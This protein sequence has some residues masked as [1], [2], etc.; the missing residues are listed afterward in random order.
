MIVAAEVGPA[1]RYA[2]PSSATVC[3]CVSLDPRVF[4][5]ET[6]SASH[7][8]NGSPVLNALHVLAATN[9]LSDVPFLHHC[10]QSLPAMRSPPTQSLFSKKN[11]LDARGHLGLSKSPFP[12]S[13]CLHRMRILL[14][15]DEASLSKRAFTVPSM[16][17]PCLPLRC[18]N[19]FSHCVS[20]LSM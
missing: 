14:A 12:V 4:S 20:S 10:F 3:V 9:Q 2:R 8:S 7:S 6:K 1:S 13:D 5:Q 19:T 11:T 15:T 17:P 18:L 16:S